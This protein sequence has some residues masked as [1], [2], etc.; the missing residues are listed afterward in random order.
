MEEVRV[1]RIVYI[2]NEKI[3]L[4]MNDNG[5]IYNIIYRTVYDKYKINKFILNVFITSISPL[6]DFILETIFRR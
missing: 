5:K 1:S 3:N 4:T 6:N 2:A